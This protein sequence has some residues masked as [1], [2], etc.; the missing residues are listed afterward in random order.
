MDIESDIEPNN[1]IKDPECPEQQDLSS[2]PNVAGLIRPTQ[3]S[4][5]ETEKGL[6]T[7]CTI[8]TR[9][10]KGVKKK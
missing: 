3:K 2:T 9:R 6:V 7:V 5:R 1:S 8:K 4:A 10:I